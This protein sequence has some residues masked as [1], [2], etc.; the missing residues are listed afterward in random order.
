LHLADANDEASKNGDTH[1]GEGAGRTGRGKKRV[2]AAAYFALSRLGKSR[3]S[4][5]TITAEKD[6]RKFFL[7]TVNTVSTLNC[8]RVKP[9]RLARDIDTC[10]RPRVFASIRE[11]P[12]NPPTGEFHP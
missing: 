4:L 2:G 3:L 6:S 10:P 5:K 7:F 8:P 11:F 1:G 12:F 9:S